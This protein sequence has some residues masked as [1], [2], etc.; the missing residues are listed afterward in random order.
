MY[1]SFVLKTINKVKA[2]ILKNKYFRRY[3]LNNEWRYLNEVVN[4]FKEKLKRSPF[5]YEVLER[6]IEELNPSLLKDVKEKLYSKSYNW[7]INVGQYFFYNFFEWTKNLNYSQI[8]FD[9]FKAKWWDLF[10]NYEDNI[11]ENRLRTLRFPEKL[12]LELTN[13]CN[14]N[15]IMCGVG[16]YGYDSSRNLP[17]D[18]LQNLNKNV[19]SKVKIIRLNGLGESTILPNFNDYLKI[20]SGNSARLELVTNLIIQNNRI[21]DQLME[22]NTYFLISC[23]NAN[24][25]KYEMIRKGA[26]FSSF[27]RNLKYIGRNVSSSIQ[28]QI[29]FTL[30]NQNKYDLLEV[31]MMAHKYGL[32]GVIVNVVKTDN[33]NWLDLNFLRIHKEFERAYTY[34]KDYGILLKL[35]DHLGKN[36]VNPKISTISS[37]QY[38][39]NPWKEVYIRYNGDL[40]VCNMLNPYIYGNCKDYPFEKIWNGLN[41]YLFRNLVN[42][43]YSHYYCQDC[44]FLV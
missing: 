7:L 29:I 23:D 6:F 15:C 14:L 37:N 4:K 3:D 12:L 28:A 18:L 11:K 42:T 26:K 20:I 41:S 5:I 32:G 31:L 9:K 39:R 8:H 17:L 43:K 22:K 27:K 33:Y 2:D 13:N 40:T 1:R 36:I 34:A 44:Y 38:C 24:P 19:L 35:P 30:M 25:R 16:K 21:W 10:C